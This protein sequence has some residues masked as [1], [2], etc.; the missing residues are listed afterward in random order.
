MNPG[1][2]LLIILA[3]TIMGSLTGLLISIRFYPL[4]EIRKVHKHMLKEGVKNGEWS[5]VKSFVDH[6]IKVVVKPNCETLYSLAFIHRKEGP[7]VLHIP[8]FSN[9]ASFAFL[10]EN[11]HVMGYIT[12]KD[13]QHDKESTILIH[14]T[15]EEKKGLEIP[16]IQLDSRLCWII[17]RFGVQNPEEIPAINLFQENIRLRKLSDGNKD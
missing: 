6:H 14:Y 2:Y 17:G 1:I 15:E 10:D 12:N 8:A 3:A 11:T 5:H 7:Y 9:Y 4:W 13:I 16:A